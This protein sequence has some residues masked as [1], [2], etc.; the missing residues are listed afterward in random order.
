MAWLVT[1]CLLSLF[2]TQ[3]VI[4]FHVLLIGDSV[5]RYIVTDWCYSDRPKPSSKLVCPDCIFWFEETGSKWDSMMCVK[6]NDSIANVH[7][8]GSRDTGP[9]FSKP[10]VAERDFAP[11]IIRHSIDR[12]FDRV[13]VPDL[14]LYQ[15]VLWDVAYMKTVYEGDNNNNQN[16]NN[17]SL[18]GDV[19]IR[20]TAIW[21][22]SVQVYATNIRHRIRDV[23]EAVAANLARL[24][25]AGHVNFGLHTGVTN[26]H[27]GELA[28]GFNDVLRALAYEHNIT[29]F[30]LDAEVWSTYNWD[31]SKESF[32]MRDIVHP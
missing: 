18:H 13:G 1:R 11:N 32:V 19:G 7:H 26:K 14:I 3:L 8:F 16:N 31:R 22:E 20:N 25:L 29:L 6:G 30:D 5:D 17:N 23:Q 4:G 27:I 9:Y 28:N 12:Y 10:V 21:H 15:A 24:H 2:V